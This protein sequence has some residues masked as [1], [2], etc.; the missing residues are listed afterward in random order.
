MR[1]PRGCRPGRAGTSGRRRPP[2]AGLQQ[3]M[4]GEGSKAGPALSAAAQ[5]ACIEAYGSGERVRRDVVVRVANVR[6]RVV[7]RHDEAA[8]EGSI[9]VPLQQQTSPLRDLGVGSVGQPLLPPCFL[10]PSPREGGVP[11]QQHPSPPSSLAPHPEKLRCSCSTSV[12][13]PS[14][15]QVGMPLMALYE[16]LAGKESR[17]RGAGHGLSPVTQAARYACL[18]SPHMTDWLWPSRMQYSKAGRYVSQRSRA[19]MICRG[20]RGATG[21]WLAKCQHKRR[22]GEVSDA[23]R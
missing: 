10:D 9:G 14:D 19:P 12:R 18:P 22:R 2:G 21:A 8:G 13:R 1:G 4:G 3:R 16:H 23:R 15:A 6:P 11:P 20:A 7:V 5:R 17:G